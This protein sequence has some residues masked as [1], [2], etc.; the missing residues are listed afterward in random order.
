MDPADAQRL[1]TAAVEPAEVWA[2]LGAGGGTFAAA[3][4][5]LLGPEGSVLAIDRDTRALRRVRGVAGGAAVR[6]LGADFTALPPVP[7]Q[8]GLLLANALHFVKDQRATLER[9]RGL[10]RPPG[11][12]VVLEYDLER[13]SLWVP[14]PLSFARLQRLCTELGWPAPRRLAEQPSRYQ[15]SGMY[16]ALITPLA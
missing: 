5:A 1:I 2:D 8:D 6:T 11:K 10:L 9:L 16:S 14:Y 15:R 12:L 13:A 4:S 3:L 7:A